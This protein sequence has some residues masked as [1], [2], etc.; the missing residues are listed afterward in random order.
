MTGDFMINFSKKN[1]KIDL[2]FFYIISIIFLSGISGCVKKSEQKEM[3]PSPIQSGKIIQKD[4]PIYIDTFGTF[5]AN[6]D[7]DIKSEVTEILLETHINSGQFVTNGQLLFTLDSREFKADLDKA[8]A[9]LSEDLAQLKMKTD[10]LARNKKLFETQVISAEAY[11]QSQ[12]TYDAASAKVAFDKAEVELAQIQ[13]DYC[14]IH[15]P[16]DARA[17]ATS[18]DPGNLIMAESPASLVN[19][20]QVD[21]LTLNF[22]I[23]EK[24]LFDVKT[25]MSKSELKVEIFVEGNTNVYSGT[26]NFLDNKVDDQTGT[27]AVQAKVSNKNKTLWPGQFVHVKLIT[28]VEKNAIL[29]PYEAVQLGRKGQYLF[30]ITEKNTAEIKFLKVGQREGDYIIIKK[31]VKPGEKVVTVGQLGLYPGATVAETGK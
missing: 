23:P 13:L 5:T 24:H 11:E 10:D 19:I 27:I 12:T 28:G 26:V 15:S 4:V 21:P 9:T 6:L 7:V 31:G 2:L 3:P 14:F 8:K 1:K 16:M 22:T 25:A 17:G 29:A 30:S 18:F 20:K